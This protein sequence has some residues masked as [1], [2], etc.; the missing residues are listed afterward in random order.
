MTYLKSKGGSEPDS[1]LPL[2]DSGAGGHAPVRLR[3]SEGTGW[4]K[5]SLSL[6]IV[7]HIFCV[8][9]APNSESYMG[10]VFLN[11]MKPYLFFFEMTNHWNFFSPNPE[12]PVFVDYQL[13]N[14]KGDAYFD[15]RWPETG[16][17]F[18]WKERQTRRV[19]AADFM[20]NQ[21]VSAEK[22]MA[23]YL[24]HRSPRPEAVRLWR[25][26]EPVPST[27]D[28]LAGK[29]KLGDGVVSERKFVAH[30]FCNSLE[31]P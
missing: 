28:I 27:V 29:R 23:N 3:S 24:C 8:L 10:G 30:V 16:E 5:A 9:L 17:S 15:G 26:M 18:F 11:V 22:M 2:N 31:T 19:T 4:L 1:P 14:M 13:V 7:F 6:F 21:E 20:V 12:P 25:V